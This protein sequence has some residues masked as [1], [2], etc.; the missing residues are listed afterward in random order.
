M[1]ATENDYAGQGQKFSPSRSVHRVADGCLKR[2]TRM[3][4]AGV[5][6]RRKLVALC[7][8]SWYGD[9]SWRR[10]SI[11]SS[12]RRSKVAMLSAVGNAST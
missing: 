12:C 11:S 1:L 10:M 2:V 3:S 5:R 6:V 8:K 7:A 9:V 4:G